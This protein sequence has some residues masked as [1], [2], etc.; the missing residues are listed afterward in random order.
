MRLVEA[1]S[2]V[3]AI[4]RPISVWLTPSLA[5]N[6]GVS[7]RWDGDRMREKMLSIVMDEDEVDDS[8]NSIG[9]YGIG[10]AGIAGGRLEVEC[11]LYIL[12]I[13]LKLLLTFVQ[14]VEFLVAE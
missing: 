2:L 11:L 3:I 1:E 13:P 12:I 5:P 10:T 8:C 14:C 6:P 4:Q 7:L 9:K